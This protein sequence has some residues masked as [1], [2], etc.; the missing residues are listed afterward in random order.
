MARTVLVLY[1]DKKPKEEASYTYRT[2]SVMGC[3]LRRCVGC[4]VFDVISLLCS[5]CCVMCDVCLMLLIVDSKKSRVSVVRH[6]FFVR[7]ILLVLTVTPAGPAA[8][9][10]M[11]GLHSAQ[12]S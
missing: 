5:M 1:D 2:A 4:S 9:W 6:D 3:V 8:C 7:S 10:P 12:Q 11:C